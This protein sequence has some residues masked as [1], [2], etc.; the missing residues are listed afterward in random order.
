VNSGRET[1]LKGHEKDRFDKQ[2]AWDGT[3]VTE[4]RNPECDPA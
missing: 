2:A 3:A 4:E 1:G